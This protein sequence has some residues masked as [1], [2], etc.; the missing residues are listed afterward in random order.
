MINHELEH[1]GQLGVFAD[2]DE[3]RSHY[4][5][6][7][8]FHQIVIARYHVSRSKDKAGQIVKFRDQADHLRR[9]LDRI[10]I[11][12]IF[13]KESAEFAQR[14][15]PRYSLDVARHMICD[16]LLEEGIQI[17]NL[18]LDEGKSTMLGSSVVD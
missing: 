7:C 9:F 10:G 15:A 16:D 14:N 8:S 6:D 4:I 12:I 2:I 17:M 11:E 1:P 13:L 5:G 3:F 18:I